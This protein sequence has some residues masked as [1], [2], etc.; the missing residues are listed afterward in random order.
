MMNGH[1]Y[2]PQQ[3]ARGGLEGRPVTFDDVV[4][5][6]HKLVQKNQS[7]CYY[8]NQLYGSTLMLCAVVG[9]ECPVTSVPTVALQQWKVARSMERR[10]VCIES[11]FPVEFAT[12]MKVVGHNVFLTS[13]QRLFLS[14][15]DEVFCGW[16]TQN[17]TCSCPYLV[18][19]LW[20]ILYLK[21]KQPQ[22]I[23]EFVRNRD[24]GHVLL[25]HSEMSLLRRNGVHV[26]RPLQQDTAEAVKELYRIMKDWAYSL[27]EVPLV[28]GLDLSGI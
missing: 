24:R 22:E 2:S 12:N 26:M 8:P 18:D 19:F 10:P 14:A 15:R 5:M 27:R 17:N 7:F 6:C 3:N 23:I 11:L 13:D 28:D 20:N 1:V 25:T 9:E 4:H 21:L 16:S